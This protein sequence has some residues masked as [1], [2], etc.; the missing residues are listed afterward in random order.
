[1]AR[2]LLEGIRQRAAARSMTLTGLARAA[3]MQPGNLRRMLMSTTA[4]PRLGSVMRLLPPLHCQVDPAGAHT[5]GE[6]VAFLDTERQ[7]QG[8]TWELLLTPIGLDID[9]TRASFSRPDR[10]SLEVFARLGEALHIDF[11]LVD[12]PTPSMK[13]PRATATAPHPA[14]A[15]AISER[16]A[17]HEAETI[18][19]PR[20]DDE[21]AGAQVAIV[22]LRAEL[23]REA[24]AR[25]K[26]ETQAALAGELLGN[27]IQAYRLQNQQYQVALEER[28]AAEE[29]AQAQAA[30]EVDDAVTKLA[31]AD[32][33]ALRDAERA[34][35]AERLLAVENEL[36]DR[37][38]AEADDASY[39]T[40]LLAADSIP[41][42]IT[43]FARRVLGVPFE[44]AD[45]A[46]DALEQQ[47]GQIAG[48]TRPQ[49]EAEA[50]VGVQRHPLTWRYH[51]PSDGRLRTTRASVP[52]GESAS[53]WEPGRKK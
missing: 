13:Y 29:R 1:M 45:Q 40:G 24:A 9:K 50:D 26:A 15:P 19:P 5:A 4:S 43:F 11:E 34:R 21:L 39:L 38:K 33:M 16:S 14:T 7:R 31:A 35:L 41:D 36:A 12:D 51:R 42:V 10:M 3:E 30:R 47:S 32:A 49:P 17:P 20:P 8:W 22:V 2:D 46:F 18:S 48:D 44:D 28:R 52:D 37:R 53:R 27:W 23:T 6:L 25:A